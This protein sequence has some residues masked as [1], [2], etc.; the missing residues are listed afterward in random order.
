MVA[1]EVRYMLSCL[2]R[3][4]FR[5]LWK[6]TFAGW[7]KRP[8][9]IKCFQFNHLQNSS[10][11]SCRCYFEAKVF[12]LS[13]LYFV[14][15]NQELS[16]ISCFTIFELFKKKIDSY[17]MIHTHVDCLVSVTNI[18]MCK[19]LTGTL[20]HEQCVHLLAGPSVHTFLGSCPLHRFPPPT[21][22]NV[23]AQ[24]TA[25]SEPLAEQAAPFLISQKNKYGKS[26]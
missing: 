1:P 26:N 12:K 19:I 4:C 6:R 21:G 7:F 13:A 11:S 18:C 8:L 14:F 10:T 5:D 15:R 22:W 17:K 25:P 16:S 9:I 24:H 2:L 20:S 23:S 3:C